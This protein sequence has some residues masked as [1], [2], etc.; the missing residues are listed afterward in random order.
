M[1]DFVW[2]KYQTEIFRC[3]QDPEHGSFCIE[4]CA[5]SGKTTV[6]V[7]IAKRLAADNPNEKIL[8]CAFNRSIRQKLSESL[9]Q[10]PNMICKTAHGLGL[11]IL[12][13][14]GLKFTVDENK[15]DK[16]VKEN[17]S[18]FCKIE[19]SDKKKS[20]YIENCRRLF[21][22]CRATQIKRDDTLIQR[23]ADD[24]GLVFVSNEVET[25]KRLM[26]EMNNLMKFKVVDPETQEKSYS[27]DF[28]DM[29]SLAISDAFRGRIPKYSYV[30]CDESQDL[31]YAQQQLILNSLKKNG[32]L[33]A[34]GDSKQSIYFFATGSA[35]TFDRFKELCGSKV[36]PLSVCYR[37]GKNII[38]TAKC[39]NPDIEAA[40][41]AIDGEVVT[42]EYLRD[43]NNGDMVLCRKTAPL[44]KVALKYISLGRS[45]FIKG[46]DLAEN[47]K[48]VLHRIVDIL[49]ISEEQKMSKEMLGYGIELYLEAT[50]AYLQ[51]RGIIEVEQHPVFEQAI[52]DTDSIMIVGEYC[53]DAHEIIN[54]I[55]NIF[56]DIENPENSIMLSTVHK[57]KGLE[58]DNVFIIRPDI[59]PYINERTNPIQRKQEMNLTYVAYTRPKKK[60]TICTG[61]EK[62]LIENLN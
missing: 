13:K 20:A 49:G 3:A 16:Y 42:T 7:E 11:S 54:L 51:G 10:Y 8:F 26:M 48:T 35:N 29:V 22:L 23:L 50:R 53:S 56:D 41:D 43:V 18:K 59:L 45:A 39:I 57:A 30:M 15:W 14:S 17:F 33:I 4:A 62:M 60:L 32:K 36:L 55:D 12:Y 31:T 46:K 61:N 58:A 44:V 2:S 37:C 19:L 1:S 9:S 24:A 25:V 52:E 40:P 47:L 27:I 6:L 38:E 21:D 28:T 34:V 5:G